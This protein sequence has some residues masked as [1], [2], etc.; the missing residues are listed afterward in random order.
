MTKL[1][2]IIR[3]LESE[4]ESLQADLQRIGKDISKADVENRMARIQASLERH[5]DTFSKMRNYINEPSKAQATTPLEKE[6]DD[7]EPDDDYGER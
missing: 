7:L 3:E 1:K 6:S 5:K 4:I 2:R